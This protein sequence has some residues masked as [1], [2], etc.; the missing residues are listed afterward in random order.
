[1]LVKPETRS[2]PSLSHDRTVTNTRARLFLGAKQR[3]VWLGLLAFLVMSCSDGIGGPPTVDSGAIRSEAS[4]YEPYVGWY[5]LSDDRHILIT[6]AASGGLQVANFEEPAFYR[7]EAQEN[8]TFELNDGRGGFETELVFVEDEE[9][10][11]IQARWRDETDRRIEASRVSTFGY[12]QEQ[13]Q[14]EN[15]DISLTGTLMVP[16]TYGP[17]PAVVFIHGSGESDRDNRWAFTIANRIAQNG[18]AVLLPDKRG[19]GQS[20]GDWRQ[21]DLDDLAEDALAA[22]AMLSDHPQIDGSRIGLVGLSQGG[23]IVPLAAAKSD[24]V[25]FVI[26]IVGGATTLYETMAYAELE[27]LRDAGL[28]EA[29]GIVVVPVT[30]FLMDLRWPRWS[31]VAGYDPIPFW[32]ELDVP[33]LVIYGEEDNNVPVQDSVALLEGAIK[34]DASLDLTVRVFPESGHALFEPGTRVVRE[35]FLELLASWIHEST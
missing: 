15:G 26:D 33:G 10:Q 5:E 34:G 32:E 16:R 23:H 22:V 14:F 18:V 6:W 20:G 9:G 4:S 21:A 8:G 2:E 29:L 17:H 27:E 1:M 24:E 35:D 12:L 31:E 30:H 7:L 11:V 19:S 3:G 13:V 28:A 25:A